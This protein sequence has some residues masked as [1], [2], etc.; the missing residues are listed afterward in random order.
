M[1]KVL[2]AVSMLIMGQAYAQDLSFGDV[3][4][5]L[6]KG[7]SNL[8]LGATLQA[9]N[10]KLKTGATTQTT[11]REGY[12]LRAAY[13]YALT[14]RFNL[15]ARGQY[16]YR[17]Q[18]TDESRANENYYENGFTNPQ[19][20][21]NYRVINQNESLVNIDLGLVGGIK[22]Q[23]Q[24][25]GSSIGKNSKDGNSADGRNSLEGNVR[26]GRK[27]NEANEWQLALGG[28]YRMDGDQMRQ[29]VG[30][31]N[32][33]YD[34]DSSVDAYLRAS[35]QYRPVQELMFLM[36]VQQNKIAKQKLDSG[37]NSIKINDH[38][39][40]DVGFTSK[41]LVTDTFIIRVDLSKKVQPDYNITQNGV[42]S[43]IKQQRNN[44]YGLGFD[45]LF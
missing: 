31:S 35:Y 11:D 42:K 14:D 25:V 27:W 6:K 37:A 26:I 45:F 24:K 16:I 41:F 43:S 1:K 18:V 17:N 9:D 38:D 28:I 23:D 8:N 34:M 19:I 22:I 21:A 13:S 7:Q 39:N 44:V 10:Y 30:A 15:F 36:Y 29:Q 20:G 40:W 32:L 12:H 2:A 5:F 4:Y 3:N 33:K